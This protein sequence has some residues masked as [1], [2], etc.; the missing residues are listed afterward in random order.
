MVTGSEGDSYSGLGNMNQPT[1]LNEIK[2]FD[3]CRSLWADPHGQSI[4]HGV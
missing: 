1:M 4:R 3:F 2:N